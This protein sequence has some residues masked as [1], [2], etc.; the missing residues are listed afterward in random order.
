LQ[1]TAVDNV[2]GINFALAT[3]TSICLRGA[4]LCTDV[5]FIATDNEG[6]RISA[7]CAGYG[8]V[9]GALGTRMAQR[10]KGKTG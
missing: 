4:C 3:R 6:K 8:V 7:D 1:L 5:D 10:V 9:A 2:R